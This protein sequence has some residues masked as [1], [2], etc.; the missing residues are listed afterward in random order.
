MVQKDGARRRRLWMGSSRLLAS[1]RRIGGELRLARITDEDV[2]RA[3]TI[4]KAAYG[5]GAGRRWDRIRR[6]HRSRRGDTVGRGTASDDKAEGLAGATRDARTDAVRSGCNGD[7][8]SGG[9]W[10]RGCSWL[11]D[12]L[13]GDL[14]AD[15][16]DNGEGQRIH[17][18]AVGDGFE[19]S[20]GGC[21]DRI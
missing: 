8:C 11:V 16:V 1:H 5:D 10:R 17:A 19:K 2:V 12:E 20:A 4:G 9:R 15:S 6:C 13:G 21:D 3:R 14:P 7:R 18:A